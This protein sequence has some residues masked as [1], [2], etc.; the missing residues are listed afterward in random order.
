MFVCPYIHWDIH[1]LKGIKKSEQYRLLCSELELFTRCYSVTPHHKV[2][3]ENIQNVRAV[4]GDST[5]TKSE[6]EANG[7]IRRGEDSQED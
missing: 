6:S 1:R 4:C 7:K 3:M 5:A 2:I